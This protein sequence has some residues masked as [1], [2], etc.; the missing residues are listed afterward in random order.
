MH[1]AYL[2]PQELPLLGACFVCSWIGLTHESKVHILYL[3]GYYLFFTKNK[4]CQRS[5]SGLDVKVL[6]KYL[7]APS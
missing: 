7:L 3:D 1:V 4:T 2:I 6:V 5:K